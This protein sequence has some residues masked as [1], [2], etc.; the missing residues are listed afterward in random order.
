MNKIYSLK[1]CPVTQGLIAVSE[2]ASRV[3]KRTSRKLKQISLISVS[4]TCLSFPM[5]SQAGIVRDDISYQLF[6]DFAE[7][8]GLFV[9]G[10]T[11][12]PVYDKNGQLVGRLDK[13]PMADFSSVSTSGVATLISPQYLASVKHNSGYQSVSFGDGKNTYTI[14]DRNDHPSTDFHA[15]RLNKLVTEVAPVSVTAEG[16]KVNAYKNTERYTEFYRVGSGA[17]Y[18]KDRDGKLTRIAGGYAFK[19]GGTIGTPLISNGTIVTNPGQTFNPVNGIIPSY[20]V[21]GD[22]GSPLFAYD[23][24]Q[25]KWVMVGV[26]RSYA[27]LTGATSWW[28]V[29]PTDYLNKVMEEDFDTPVAAVSG[30]EPLAWHFDQNTGTGTLSQ[31]T[32]TWDMHGQKGKD[33]NSGKNLVF[34]GQN[35]AILLKDSVTQ[36]AGYLEFK[37]SYTVS[38]DAGKTWTGAGIVT[39]KGTNVT[40]KVNGV[41]GDNLHKL[42][43][44]TLTVSGIG[45]NPGGLKTG[46]GTVIL[47]QKPDAAGNVQAFSSVNLAS[48]RPT[49]VLADSRQVN[50]DNISWGYRG[51]VLD[52]NGNDITFTRLRVSDY[53]AVIAN[54]AANKSHLSL[55]LSTANNEEVSVPI[56]TVN[57]FGGKGTPGSLYS[58]NLNGQTSYYILKSSTYGNTLWGNSLNDPK[59]WEYVGTDKNKAIQTVKDRVLAERAKQPVIYHG[60]LIGN[61]DVTIP[62]LPGERKVVMDGSVNLPGGNLS[63]EGGSLIFQGHPVIHASVNG[64]APVSLTQKDWETRQFTLKT[65]SLKNADFHLS[66]NAVLNGDIQSDNSHI[67]L[68]SNKVIIDKNDSTGNYVNP[69]EGTSSPV[70]SQYQGNITLQKGSTLDINNRFTGGIEAHDSQVNVTSSEAVLQDSGVFVNSALSVRDGGHLTAQKG[71]Y[72]D[73]RVQI[74]KNGTLSLSGTPVTGSDSQFTPMLS[75]TEGYD[76]TGNN[77]TLDIRNWAHVSGDIHATSPSTVRIGTDAPGTLSSSVSSALAEGMFG[78]YNAAYY[79]AITGGKGNVSMNSGLWQLTGDS[80]VNN[81]TAR[82]SRVQSEEKGAFRTLTVNTLDATGSDFVLRTDLKNADKISVTGKASGSDNTLNVSFMKNPA[83]GQSL[84]IPLVSAPAGTAGDVFKAGTRV[85]GFS[86]VTP[87]LHVDTT[88]GS[89]KWILDGFRAEADK[90]AAA[91]ADS[92]MNA[93]YKNFMTEVNNLN[94]R[95]GELRDTKGDAG[96]WARIMNGAGSADGGYSDNYTHVQVG[97]DKKHALDGMDLFTGVTMTY[98]DSSADSDAFSGK[99]KSVGGGLYAS[100]LFNSGAYIDLIGKYIHHDNDYTGNFAGLGTKHYGTHSWY[101]GAETGYRYHLTEDTFIEPQAELVYGAVSGKTFRW[102]EGNMDLSMKNKDF[103]PLVGRTGVELGK[104]FSGKDWSVTARAGTSWQFDLLNNGE[105]VLRD[106][107]GEKRI[108]GEKDSRMLFNVGMNAQIKDNMRFGL[109]FEKSAFGKYNVDNAINAN[110]RYMF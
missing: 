72:S 41:A 19:T 32:T 91:K 5:M 106:A 59:Q 56:G 36:G 54:K 98:T 4:V 24:L 48:G 18:T 3:V 27:G 21:P 108:K 44:G 78:G 99:T 7:N 73:G 13:A 80:T 103:S 14:V 71:L 70:E 69:E 79:G 49:V 94:K 60:Q 40:W 34:S 88:G 12:I 42:G 96:A 45:V 30:K 6:R 51:G 68:G 65:L 31:G 67:T 63:K 89:T 62:Q 20:G 47:A 64:S 39:D 101:A 22:S 85:T 43:E 16:T 77:A 83:P 52:L 29:I 53:G 37:D 76:L 90:A 55:N 109:E 2:L 17:Q 105:T 10:A 50:P 97:F 93:G 61:M 8:K 23:S 92:F 75:M 28:N 82:N 86:R 33:L 15:P 104:T 100:A 11:D 9:P 25:K 107:S 26:L 66:R 1:Y 81:L 58:R 38:A 95:M 46:D 110:F 102:K 87:T 57:P 74:G 84:N 35:G